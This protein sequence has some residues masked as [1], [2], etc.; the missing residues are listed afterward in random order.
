[1]LSRGSP[2]INAGSAKLREVQEDTSID[3]DQK[4][5]IV[6]DLLNKWLK[7]EELRAE[8]RFAS[9]EISDDK[10]MEMPASSEAQGEKEMQ[11]KQ[12]LAPRVDAGDGREK[13]VV[14]SPL[15]EQV[16]EVEGI[17]GEAQVT[18]IEEELLDCEGYGVS[19][20]DIDDRTQNMEVLAP[21]EEQQEQEFDEVKRSRDLSAMEVASAPD[22][23]L[24]REEQWPPGETTS[25][26]ESKCSWGTRVAVERRCYYGG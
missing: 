21:L 25:G 19:E 3:Q 23:E 17:R 13:M 12:A 2:R 16:A 22:V 7:G 15:E 5:K 20:V 10:E 9:E 14:P 6:S 11:P 26:G 4:A 18:D 24:V 1:M 8:A